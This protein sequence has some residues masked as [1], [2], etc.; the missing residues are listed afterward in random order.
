M[1]LLL[2]P[3]TKI[4]WIMIW[5]QYVVFCFVYVNPLLFRF[6]NMRV[7]LC[8]VN[9]AIDTWDYYCC[10]SNADSAEAAQK[11]SSSIL[12]G[13]WGITI[14][15]VRKE[16]ISG[17]GWQFQRYMKHSEFYS[18]ESW[19][20]CSQQ[21]RDHPRTSSPD[22]HHVLADLE[23]GGRSPVAAA[24]LPHHDNF[25]PITRTEPNGMD[26]HDD[27]KILKKLIPN[28]EK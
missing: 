24:A 17:S 18:K 1:F 3:I 11:I 5:L 23:S 22:V 14:K 12:I 7:E 16:G 13:I 20:N 28:I 19:W 15:I 4:S 27:H 6:Q 8:C 10:T 2:R 26:Q 25:I 21:D 9:Y